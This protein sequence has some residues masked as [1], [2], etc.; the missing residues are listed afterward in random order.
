MKFAELT[1]AE[2]LICVIFGESTWTEGVH[3]WLSDSEQKAIND[4]LDEFAAVPHYGLTKASCERAVKVLRLRAGFEPRTDEE[5]TKRPSNSDTRTL[6]EVALYF[7]VT[8]ERIRQIENRT[9]RLL[10]HPDYSR[11]LKPYL[12]NM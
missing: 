10:R 6:A 1:P 3:H 8:R 2:K 9:L 7:N 5:R 11:R 12:E 4:F